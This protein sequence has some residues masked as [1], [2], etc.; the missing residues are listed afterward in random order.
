MIMGSSRLTNLLPHFVLRIVILS[1]I[2]LLAYSNHK[3]PNKIILFIKNTYP[4]LFLSFFY[5]ETSYLKNITSVNNLD[6]YFSRMEQYIW[7]CQPSLE[8]YQF[9]PQDWFNELMNVCYF[10]YY[11]LTAVICITLYILEREKSSKGI[12]IV[13]FSFYL[14]YTIY[15]FL[16]VVGPQFYFD[17]MNTSNIPPYF[18]GKIMQYILFNLE[19]PTGAFPSSH[20]GIAL[21]LSYVAYKDLKKVFYVSFPFILGICFATVYLKAHYLIDVIGAIISVPVLIVIS[22]YVYD[23]I[24]EKLQTVNPS[25]YTSPASYSDNSNKRKKSMEKQF[26]NP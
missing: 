18:F 23:K 19:E 4:L 24:N 7:G 16:P 11:F 3:F 9:M 12:F 17:T 2:A 21:I 10:S 22:S 8:F 20:V 1:L 13:V 25:L 6:I 15:D 14:Y 5:T 26:N